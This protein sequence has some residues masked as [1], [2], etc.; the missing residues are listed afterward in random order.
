MSIN[1]SVVVTVSGGASLEFLKTA[2]IAYAI[3]RSG[4]PRE[5]AW[6]S[7]AGVSLVTLAALLFGRGLQSVPLH[8]L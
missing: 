8:G 5:T 6:G 2:A 4:C 3:A 7:V 1:W